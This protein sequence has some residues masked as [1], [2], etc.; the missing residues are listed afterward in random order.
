MDVF[1]GSSDRFINES[2]MIKAKKSLGQNFLQDKHIAEKIVKSANLREKDKVLEVGP[3]QG[4]LTEFLLKKADFVLAVEKDDR[5]FLS[6]KQR[7]GNQKNLRL[8]NKDILQLTEA[9]LKKI[10]HEQPYKIVA[11]LPYNISGVFLK[12]FLSADFKPQSMTLML[13]K[14]VGE[15]MTVKAPHNNILSLS[16]RFFGEPKRVFEVK[17]GSFYPRPKV[18][19]AVMRIDNIKKRFP[20]VKEKDFFS[21]VKKGFSAKRKKLINNL[22]NYYDQEKLKRIFSELNLSENTRA[23]ELT[24]EQWVDLV[25]AL[26]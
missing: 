22:K 16:V 24:L 13:Q 12:K 2:Y 9:E 11:N 14:E 23:Q 25:L 8:V 21:L 17:P 6:L 7:F 26:S 10:F 20:Q 15:R 4:V 18:H 19:S 3:G 5:L 1:T